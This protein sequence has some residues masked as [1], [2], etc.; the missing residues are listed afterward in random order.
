MRI[1]TNFQ[2]T[3]LFSYFNCLLSISS[4][5]NINLQCQKIEHFLL[6]H[7]IVTIVYSHFF[8]DES[9][10]FITVSGEPQNIAYRGVQIY[11]QASVH[12]GEKLDLS[13][14]FNC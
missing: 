2:K 3:E 4:G 8:A 10:F 12:F 9:L 7:E 1:I 6:Q 11:Q 14:I 13:L 5:C